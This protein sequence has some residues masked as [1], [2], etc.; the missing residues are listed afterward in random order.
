MHPIYQFWLTSNSPAIEARPLYK[1]LSK[2]VEREAGEQF[3]REKLSGELTFVR[4]DYDYI[5]AAAFDTKIALD[6]YISY[7]E[8]DDDHQA[9]SVPSDI[10]HIMLITYIIH[11]G[12]IDFHIPEILP[13]RIKSNMVP[14]LQSHLG[15]LTPWGVKELP[16]HFM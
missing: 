4:D 8:L 2:Q 1:S 15:I 9:I 10:E 13:L 3:Y 16:Q 5:M 7:D 6:I 12:E 14:T 11:R